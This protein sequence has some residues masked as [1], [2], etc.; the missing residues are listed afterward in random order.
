[1]IDQSITYDNTKSLN[2]DIKK[3]AR[4][5]KEELMYYLSPV[6]SE[7]QIKDLSEEQLLELLDELIDKHYKINMKDGGEVKPTQ[8]LE[9]MQILNNMSEEEKENLQ[10]MLN[11][12]KP[13][14]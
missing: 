13:K 2:K 11:N 10:F 7:D 5:T 8:Y 14:N 4:T 9:L 6:Y 12:L 3:V 1:M